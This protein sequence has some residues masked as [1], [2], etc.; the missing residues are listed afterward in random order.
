M[1][2]GQKHVISNPS[3]WQGSTTVVDRITKEDELFFGFLLPICGVVCKFIY[4]ALDHFKCII[5]A[6]HY[7]RNHRKTVASHVLALKRGIK[8]NFILVRKK[9][10]INFAQ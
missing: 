7:D 6:L 2:T 10:N 9:E 4:S 8:E 5:K 1:C 3:H